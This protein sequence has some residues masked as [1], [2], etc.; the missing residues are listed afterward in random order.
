VG[1]QVAPVAPLSVDAIVSR[2]IG[3]DVVEPPVLSKTSFTATS[4]LKHIPQ[5]IHREL[6]PHIS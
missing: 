6:S 2:G 5:K 1:C 3:R 4:Y